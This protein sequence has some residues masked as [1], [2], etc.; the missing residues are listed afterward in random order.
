MARKQYAEVDRRPDPDQEYW[1]DDPTASVAQDDRWSPP[2]PLRRSPDPHSQD[3][4]GYEPRTAETRAADP[5]IVESR[6][7]EPS[8]A[9]PH[10]RMAAPSRADPRAAEDRWESAQS[11]RRDAIDADED[12]WDSQPNRRRAG[13]LRVEV[14]PMVNPYAIIALVAAL[15]GLFPVAI[16]FGLIAFGHPR[17]RVMAMSALLLGLAEVLIVAAALVL[18]GIT[19]PRI[20]SSTVPAAVSTETSGSNSDLTRTI[21]PTTVAAPPPVTTAPATTPAATGPISAAKGE[22]CTESQAGLL[23]AASDGSTLLCLHSGGGYRWTGPYSVSTAVYEGGSKCDPGRDKSARTPDGHA[24]ICEG[25][26][27]SS[28]WSLWVE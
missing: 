11:R 14:P 9:E 7:I 17:G 25:Q 26:G 4:R 10:P 24:L 18:A 23:G 16:V 20:T 5:W 28:I 8:R 1:A 6:M 13:R 27:R 12:R 19:L 22:V 21:V 15:L 2:P 3:P